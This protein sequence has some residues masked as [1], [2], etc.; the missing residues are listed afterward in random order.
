[1]DACIIYTAA[2]R[3]KMGFLQLLTGLATH[4]ANFTIIREEFKP[5]QPRPCD[6][7]GQL[8]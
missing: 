8:G 2:G 3:D 4:E 1:M 5:N 6:L 7:C